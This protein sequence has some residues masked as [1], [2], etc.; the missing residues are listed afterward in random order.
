MVRYILWP[1]KWNQLFVTTKAFCFSP[2]L[3]ARVGGVSTFR[4]CCANWKCA[5]CGSA[6]NLGWSLRCVRAWSIGREGFRNPLPLLLAESNSECTLFWKPPSISRARMHLQFGDF[7][8]KL[9]GAENLFEIRV[10]TFARFKVLVLRTKRAV[11]LHYRV[12]HYS[13]SIKSMK[14]GPL[15]VD[16]KPKCLH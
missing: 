3:V 13:L 15:R 2:F 5:S 1:A 16:C 8:G 6:A 4:P 12:S 9:I 14:L 7:L 11:I 10:L